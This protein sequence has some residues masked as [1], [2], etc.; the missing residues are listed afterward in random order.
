MSGIQLHFQID[1]HPV[2]YKCFVWQNFVLISRFA[3][4]FQYW[5]YKNIDMSVDCS[6]FLFWFPI[7]ICC[8]DLKAQSKGGEDSSYRVIMC[9]KWGKLTFIP[10]LS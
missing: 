9:F 4:C 7:W 5:V 8:I 1:F 6:K 10:L 3:P 2:V